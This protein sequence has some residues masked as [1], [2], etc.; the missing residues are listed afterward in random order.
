MKGLSSMTKAVR[1]HSTLHTNTSPSTEASRASRR[2]LLTALAAIPAVA[3]TTAAVAMPAADPVYAA[4]EAHR[5]AAA[6][7]DAASFA[8]GNFPDVNPTREERAE[9]A[10]L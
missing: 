5:I 4:I 7:F 8:R 3:V 9:L 6:N 10:R 1:V 2:A